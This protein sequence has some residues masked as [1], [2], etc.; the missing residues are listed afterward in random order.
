ML[1]R[2]AFLELEVTRISVYLRI[3]SRDWFVSRAD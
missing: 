3:K 2:T 1:F